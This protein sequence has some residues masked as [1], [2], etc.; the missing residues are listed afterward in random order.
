MA[1]PIPTQI[2][3]VEPIHRCA[4]SRSGGRIPPQLE[5]TAAEMIGSA[6]FVYP[7]NLDTFGQAVVLVDQSSRCLQA[8]E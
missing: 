6:G 7:A 4:D 8:S 5:A 2:F 3:G 1:G